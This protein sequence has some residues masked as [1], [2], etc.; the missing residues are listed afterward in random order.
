MLKQKEGEKS[1][2]EK[3]IQLLKRLG[4][5]LLRCSLQSD[6]ITN[7][8]IIQKKFACSWKTDAHGPEC[9]LEW[10]YSDS[11]VAI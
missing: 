5:T 9:K 8:C 1:S 11:T 3:G 10:P 4:R 7:D 6:I 2:S